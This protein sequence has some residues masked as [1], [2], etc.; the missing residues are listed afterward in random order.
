MINVVYH[1]S[2]EYIK[3]LLLSIYS[4]KKHSSQELTF[5]ILHSFNETNLKIVHNFCK[6]NN[7]KSN[8]IKV[9]KKLLDSLEVP[10]SFYKILKKNV[11]LN[12]F[13][14]QK[15]FLLHQ[16]EISFTSPPIFWFILHEKLFEFE[17]Y[18]FL[19]CDTILLSDINQLLN[20]QIDKSKICLMRKDWSYK[21][22]SRENKTYDH[23]NPS[24]T[25]VIS[26]DI[27]RFIHSAY[28]AAVKNVLTARCG[29]QH[30]FCVE[31]E[32]LIQELPFTWNFAVNSEDSLQEDLVPHL[33]HFNSIIS[34]LE[35]SKKATFY[36]MLQNIE[37]ECKIN[38]YV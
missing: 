13:E 19:D 5:H 29:L 22:F 7:L 33:L 15:K 4:A 6:K 18:V 28:Q 21:S 20:Q 10:F 16:N 38:D 35:K 1:C 17:N 37:R 32:G 2:D 25:V 14:F 24:V 30:D 11:S 36:L 3:F 26:R 27:H 31:A 23:F 12:L 9:N 34:N 8:L